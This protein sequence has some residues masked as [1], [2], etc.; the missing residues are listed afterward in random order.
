MNFNTIFR[1][2]DAAMVQSASLLK[3]LSMPAMMGP[4][5]RPILSAHQLILRRLSKVFMKRP[6]PS[7]WRRYMLSWGYGAELAAR[8][9]DEL[10]GELDGPVKRIAA[11]DTFCA[12]QPKLEDAILPQSDA[13]VA[14]VKQLLEY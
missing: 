6:A 8:I 11:T 2:F 14:T 7:S 5:P 13:V 1:A 12:Y 9:A 3:Y 10:F 4:K